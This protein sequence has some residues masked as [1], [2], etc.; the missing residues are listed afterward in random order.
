MSPML[1]KLTHTRRRFLGS[2]AMTMSAAAPVL[3]A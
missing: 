2:A 3:A 1:P